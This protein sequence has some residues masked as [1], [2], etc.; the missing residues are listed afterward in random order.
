M[1]AA[2]EQIEARNDGY[3]LAGSRVGLNVLIHDIWRG[4]SREG[5][6]QS[7]PSIGE[8]DWLLAEIKIRCQPEC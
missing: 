2:S 5:I 3:Y 4:P 1:V 6:L 8:Q 7:Y